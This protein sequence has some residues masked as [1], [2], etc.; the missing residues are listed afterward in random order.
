MLTCMIS[1]NNT[2]AHCLVRPNAAAE[3]EKKS[4]CGA[5]VPNPNNPGYPTAWKA[6]V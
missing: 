4:A 1:A 3:P 6:A 5:T 2:N